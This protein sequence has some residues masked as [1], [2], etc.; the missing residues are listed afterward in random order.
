[1]TYLHQAADGTFT[2]N[3]SGHQTFHLPAAPPE[4][5]TSTAAEWLD[6]AAKLLVDM[7]ETTSSTKSNV[8]LSD[9]GREKQLEPKRG[10]FVEDI[11][12]RWRAI[13]V[14]EE[15]VSTS[16]A[17]YLAPPKLE[18]SNFAGAVE[19]REIRDW[20][21]SQSVAERVK[22]MA[23]I[24]RDVSGNERL[25]VAL[26]RS[27][28]RLHDSEAKF[29]Q[30]TWAAA[31]RERNADVF[32]SFDAARESFE[33]ARRGLASIVGISGATLG[34]GWDR[35]RVVRQLLS[36]ENAYAPSGYGAWGITAPEVA[37]IKLRVEHEK[38]RAAGFKGT[39]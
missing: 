25:M 34:K 12:A 8:D 13:E 15:N 16:E 11:A 19:D 17:T 9:V 6:G 31:V 27:P 7:I 35:E 37:R 10:K 39:V 2:Y 28:I 3:L 33:W 36:S 1:M 4:V 24:Q 18:S 32:A 22:A 5:A 30:D 23:D 38:S 21:R 26:M 29:M 20:W 14:R